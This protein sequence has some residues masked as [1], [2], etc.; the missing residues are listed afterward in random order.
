MPDSLSYNQEVY[1][2]FIHISSS[3]IAFLLWILGKDVLLPY[4]IIATILFV[5]LDYLRPYISFLQKIYI[6]H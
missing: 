4:I 5:L 3:I 1:R 6:Y 2:K